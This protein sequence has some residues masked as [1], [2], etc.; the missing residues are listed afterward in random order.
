MPFELT[1][2]PST[3]QGLVNNVFKPFLRKFVLVYF[4]DILIYSQTLKA[5][6]THLHTVLEILHAKSL[7]AKRL[8][9]HFAVHEIDYL[10]HLIFGEGVRADPSKLKSMLEWPVPRSV[11]SFW[12]F[13]GLSSY[14]RKFIK[15]YGSTVAPLAQW[16]VMLLV[17][18]FGLSWCKKEDP[19]H[20][21]T[22]NERTRHCYF[23]PMKKSFLLW[24]VMLP[25][26]G[27]ICW[28]ILSKLILTASTYTFAWTKIC[29]NSSTE[30]DVK[31]HG[32]WL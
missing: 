12:S 18:D 4:Y 26:G 11:K 30:V 25:N 31:A 28:A 10:G 22:S 23:R 3:F 19:L 20:S 27:H 6:L 21:I 1:N 14:Y 9:C 8:K 7:F 32:L 24:L 29:H 5:Y 2:A 17:L 15:G 16:S 13:L